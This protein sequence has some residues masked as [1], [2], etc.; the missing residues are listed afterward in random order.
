[1]FDAP[2]LNLSTH[3]DLN[4][5]LTRIE[6]LDSPELNLSTH[7][8][9]NSQLTRLL[10]IDVV[11]VRNQTFVQLEVELRRPVAVVSQDLPTKHLTDALV[12]HIH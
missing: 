8:N 4:S 6:T 3:P 5:R 12:I 11:V 9:W 10:Q 7:P 2:E 1:M